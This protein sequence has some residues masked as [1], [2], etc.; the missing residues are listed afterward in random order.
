MKEKVIIRTYSAGVHFGTLVE[1]EKGEGGYHVTLE[2]TRRI[3]QWSGANSISELATLGTSK[4]EDCKFS[5]PTRKI[6][7]FAIEINYMTDEAIQSIESVENWMYA[8]KSDKVEKV[9]ET[10]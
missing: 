3:W 6:K 9:L 7:L 5:L 1:S 4:P 10:I 8:E 2:K